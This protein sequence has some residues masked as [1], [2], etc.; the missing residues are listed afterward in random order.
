MKDFLV[1]GGG[2]AGLSTAARLSELGSVTVLEAEDALGYHASGRS[3][4]MFEENYGLPSTVALNRASRTYLEEA[5]VLSPRGFLMVGDTGETKAARET[6]AELAMEE[7][8]VAEAV[9]MVPIVDTKRIVLAG[10]H[11]AA[12]DIDT[13]RLL[14]GYA[15]LVRADGGEVVPNA[16]VT[17]IRRTKAGWVV[18]A[19]GNEFPAKIL[20]NATGAWVD[21]VAVM[22]GI[23]PLGFTPCRRSMARVPAPGGFDVSHWPMLFGPGETWYAKP[24]AGKWLVSPADEDPVEPH[25]AWADDMVLAEG[26]ARYEAHVTEP[27]TRVEHTWAGL[28]TF[29]PDRALVIGYDP[30]DDAFLWVAGQGGYGIQSSPAYSRLAADLVAGRGSELDPG[31]VAALSPA[32][33]QD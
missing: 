16:R 8:S 27:V 19:G 4:A 30:A 12:Q 13:D 25:D 3:A 2:M 15:R 11:A 6:I 17:S 31:V 28:R 1:I 5:G 7:I 26:V 14:Q 22:A 20:V 9:A 33:F 24:D 23:A 10:Y 21:Q 29:S 32:R 18:S